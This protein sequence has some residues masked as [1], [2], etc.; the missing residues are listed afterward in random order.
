[1]SFNWRLL[2]APEDVLDY[3]V[4]HEVCH[5]EVPDHS[6]RFW[7]PGGTPLPR[8]QQQERWLRRYGSALVLAAR[9]APGAAPRTGVSPFSSSTTTRFTR[10]V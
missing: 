2:M 9:V 6:Q 1:M 5:L 10:P 4:W 3:V 8:P 7:R